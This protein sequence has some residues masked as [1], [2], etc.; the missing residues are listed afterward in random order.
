MS[1]D[2]DLSAELRERVVTAAAER[3]PLVIVGAGTKAFYGRAA[4]GVPL[5]VSGHRGIVSYEPKELV[6]TARCGTSLTELEQTVAEQGQ[7]L[8]FEPP[9]FADSATLG[10]AVAAG[11]SG[12]RRPYT[13]A[14]RDFVLGVRLLNGRGEILRLGGEVMKNV[15][16]YDLSRLVTGALGT[17]GV[18]LEVSFKV[19]PRPE[20]EITVQQETEAAAAIDRMNRWSGQPLPLSAAC[21]DGHHLRV[22]LSGA[23]QAVAAAQRELGGEEAEQGASFWRDMRD[24]RHAFFTQSDRPLWR[25]SIRPATPP[26][27][28]GDEW[29]DWGGAQRWLRSDRPASEIRAAATAAGGHATLFRGGDRDG[30]VFQPLSDV[31]MR[32][33]RELK[34]AFD[35]QSL[36]NPGRLY[37]GI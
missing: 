28:L 33:H 20:R 24:Q 35:P 16:G 37:P 15:A 30:E 34:R 19:L 27:E 3:T 12:P 22:R 14:V 13:G 21:H 2:P 6:L 18:I 23:E 26:L 8:A 31:L 4:T 10:G 36:F 11:L 9:Q 1:Q 29:I 17:L 7:M 25:L 32:F 5:E